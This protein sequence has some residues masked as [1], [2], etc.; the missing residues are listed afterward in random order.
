[1]ENVPK[2]FMMPLLSQGELEFNICG[3]TDARYVNPTGKKPKLRVC[4]KPRAYIRYPI[5]SQKPITEASPNQRLRLL[6]EA[7]EL[8]YFLNYV[9]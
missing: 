9:K 1:V 8:E 3:L 7:E 2:V 4:L 5:S 6:Y